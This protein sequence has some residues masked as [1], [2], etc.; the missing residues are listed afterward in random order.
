MLFRSNRLLWV[1]R[2][3][4]VPITLTSVVLALM[5][6]VP[7]ELLILAFDVVFAGC[8]VPLALG[9]YW[10]RG[11]GEAAI[12]AILIPSLLRVVLYLFIADLGLDPRLKGIETLIPPVVSLA[13]FVG[14]SLFRGG[15]DAD[16][17]K[18]EL[19]RAV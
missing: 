7:G 9:I 4:V 17:S 8:V 1:S 14:V 18:S 12:M 5:F 3:M 19:V 10:R 15:A 6:P 16:P 13:I 2:A 11:T